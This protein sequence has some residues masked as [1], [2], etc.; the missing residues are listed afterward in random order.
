MKKRIIFAIIVLG[1]IVVCGGLLLRSPQTSPDTAGTA[2]E[3]AETGEL[4][5]VWVEVVPAMVGDIAVY[6]AETGVTAPLQSV[7]I[8]S[9]V[10][11]RIE[12]MT[13]EL[14][15]SV[16]KGEQI[17][18]IE[19]ELIRLSLD[20]A[21]AQQI[22]AAATFEKAQKDLERYKIL[23]EKEEI[24]EDEYES[25][26]LQH[27]LGRS[28]LLAADAAVKTA[29]RQLRNT[30]ITSPIAGNIAGKYIEEGNMVSVG[31]P[32]VKVV[33]IGAIK[34]RI[35]LSEHDIAAIRH[36]MP[37]GV[38]IDAFPGTTFEGTV[39]AE[40][41][42][43]AAQSHTFPLE[44]IVP[45]NQGPVIKSGMIARVTITTNTIRNVTLVPLDAVV[46][47]FGRK[48]IYVAGEKAAQERGVVLG[49]ESGEY[50][51]VVEGVEPGEL[52]VSVGQYNL[53]DGTPVRIR[54]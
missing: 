22:N 52:V 42:E 5:P 33:D 2:P 48:F 13:V 25:V 7:E 17:A 11:G 26:K 50:V 38:V 19:D 32:L 39:F 29:E 15:A 1:L 34:V 9:E 23:L 53:E 35:N 18:L 21:R 51:Q 43:A 27:E 54:R 14:G 44:I 8:S 45:N 20:Q 12:K 36:G 10:A 3:Q 47:R 30:R 46:E 6:I 16:Q 49:R 40:S 31:Q 41:P 37:A 4:E 24:S 28:A